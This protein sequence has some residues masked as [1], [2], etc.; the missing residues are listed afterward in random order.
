METL[1]IEISVKGRYGTIVD[2]KLFI[3]TDNHLKSLLRRD[4]IEAFG[5]SPGV[6]SLVKN[7]IEAGKYYGQTWKGEGSKTF[8]QAWSLPT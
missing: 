4:Y 3:M 1:G 7:I 8:A 5:N 2:G 6:N